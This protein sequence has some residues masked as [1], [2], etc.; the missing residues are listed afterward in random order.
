MNLRQVF[1]KV[2]DYST[3][4]RAFREFVLSNSEHELAGSAPVL[5]RRN[6]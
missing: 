4:E 5:V 1:L 3:A 6:F 2:G